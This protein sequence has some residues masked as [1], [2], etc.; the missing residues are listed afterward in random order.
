MARLTLTGAPDKLAEW[1]TDVGADVTEPTLSE[2][3]DGWA[4]DEQPP[5]QWFNWFQRQVY[6]V[7]SY[8]ASVS[9]ANWFT[10]AQVSATTRADFILYLPAAHTLL[11]GDS[12][13]AMHASVDGGRTWTTEQILG[14]GNSGGEMAIDTTRFIVGSA[15]TGTTT[16]VSYSTTGLDASWTTVTPD[17]GAASACTAIETN[18]PTSDEILIGA[19][20][21]AIRFATDVTSAFSTPTTSPAESGIVAALRKVGSVWFVLYQNGETYS[22]SDGGDNWAATT[23]S[24]A[25][26]A[27]TGTF[28]FNRMA[29]NADG[30]LVAVGAQDTAGTQAPAI[31]YSRDGQTWVIATITVS[32]YTDAMVNDLACVYFAGADTWFAGG[33]SN[34]A[35]DIFEGYASTDNGVTWTPVDMVDNTT[36]PVEDV[37]AVASDGRRLWVSGTTNTNNG[38]FV[39][40]S[41]SMVRSG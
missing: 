36:A 37:L 3:Q 5:A 33:G 31:A 26:L 34:T 20:N 10:L 12:S 4:T 13:E 15:G 41:L 39:A 7:Q 19:Q 14:F 16:R 30:T 29:A 6:K 35:A 18:F 27:W 40:K 23:N 11:I 25:D 9:V 17:V 8:V 2:K 1:A 38:T 24:P 28:E 32:D 21:G 22:S